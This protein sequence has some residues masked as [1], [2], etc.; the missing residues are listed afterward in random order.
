MKQLHSD[1][2]T[3]K[4]RDVGDILVQIEIAP[5]KDPLPLYPHVIVEDDKARELCKDLIN[6]GY[7][8]VK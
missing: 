1:G 6:K 5:G 8:R 2:K 4:V 7:A 3:L